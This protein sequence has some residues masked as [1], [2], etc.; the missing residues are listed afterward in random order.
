[1]IRSFLA[2]A[3][4]LCLFAAAPLA[5]AESKFID[6]ASLEASAL[7]VENGA[8]ATLE[9]MNGSKVIQLAFPA[10]KSYPGFEIAAPNG[11]W[12]LS[13]SSGVTAEVT[14]TSSAKIGV[15]LR[16][17]NAGDWKQ[18][19]W[20]SNVTWLAPGATGR[21]TVKFG[22]SFGNPGFAL[23]PA[24]VTKIKVFVNAPSADGAVTIN[25]IE[26]FDG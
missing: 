21:V 19:P 18:S 13:S 25:T 2:S 4:V 1:M 7:K 8:T 14:N 15:S 10:S 3:S 17:E 20:N 5:S 12:N 16:V 6:F 23:D 24:A 26:G 11:E 22:E 9:D